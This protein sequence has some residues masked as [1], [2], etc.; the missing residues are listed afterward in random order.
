MNIRIQ[1]L[2]IALA[3]SAGIHQAAAQSTAFTYQGRLDHGS[4]VLFTADMTFTLFTTNT[5]GSPVGGPITN[6]Y[7]QA[8]SNGLFTTT[9]DFGSGIWTGT[10]PNWLEIGVRTNGIG[11][12]TILTPRQLITPTPQSIYALNAAIATSASNFSGSV[13]GDVSGPQGATEVLS[14]GGQ[15][16]ANIASG[17]IAANAATTANTPGTIVARD[18][19]GNFTASSVTLGGSLYLPFPAIIYSGSNT[20]MIEQGSVFI[21]AAD[22]PGGLGFA[23]HSAGTLAVGVHDVGV[24]DSA[25]SGGGPGFTSLDTGSY[26]TAIGEAAL[27]FNT[28]GSNNTAGGYAALRNNTS[29][30][31][32][33][34]DGY[35]ALYSNTTGSSNTANG[36]QA[37]Y[38]NTSGYA[39]TANGHQA[40]YSNTTGS[41][42]TA[43]GVSALLN[44]TS[45]HW[46]SAN[47]IETLF[48]NTSGY[49]NT[50]DGSL[51]LHQ[52][53]VGYYNTANGGAA[54]YSNTNGYYNS[55]NGAN[56]LWHNTSGYDNTANGMGALFFNTTGSDNTANGYLALDNNTTGSDNT[57]DGDQALLDTTGINNI[58]VGFGAGQN[59]TSG[60]DNIDIGNQGVAGE[61]DTI[62]IGTINNVATNGPANT[63]IAGIWDT[64]LITPVQTVVVDSSGHLGV[65]AGS[66][67]GSGVTSVT[68]N[69]HITAAPTTGAVVVGSDATPLDTF[70]TI[71]SRD[72]NGSFNANNIALGSAANCPGENGV[73]N[74]PATTATSGMITLGGCNDPFL[75]GYGSDNFFGGLNAGN[76]TLTGTWNVGVGSEALQ[77]VT[78]GYGNTASGFAALSV[79]TTGYGNT[80]SGSL[81]LYYN[82]TGNSNT[83][84]GFQALYV[85][86]SGF[87][88]TANGYQALFANTTGCQNTANGANALW[89]NTT[90]SNNTANGYLALDN[91]STGS[92]NTADGDQALL[93]TTG[94]NNIGVG[95]EAGQNLTTGNNNID[96]GNTGLASDNDTIRIGTVL[97]VSS[98]GPASTYIAGIY[99]SLVAGGTPVYAL[100]NGQLGTLTSSARYKQN[101]QS[102]ADASDV[103]L[104]LRP[105]T[106]QY[107]P[108]LDP[109]GIPQF[110][111]VAEEVDKIDPDLVVHDDRHGIYT[112]RY[113]AVNAMLLNEF[114]KQHQEIASLKEKAARV[115]SLESRLN[116]LQTLVKQLAGQK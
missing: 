71:V 75:H 67:S 47:G 111:L 115:D 31:D 55:A 96:I 1:H 14:V 78:T 11:A 100:A 110:G 59:L 85:N 73:L 79:N 29:G 9:I 103:L 101:I 84:N 26:N 68:G 82:A 46:N 81:A 5:D 21:G 24:G 64:T 34:A 72:I 113:E 38:S 60:N 49:H 3:L 112:V 10:T 87:S 89:N 58:G 32:N 102:M 95:F 28:T 20:M 108:G 37:L 48:N 25:L 12:F 40:L 4:N 53:T 90:G 45:G 33:K 54:L 7:V 56:A 23:G 116:E 104:S 35:E 70:G 50:A 88:D 74:L 13:S 93:N 98:N 16:A 17:V 106:Y 76:F 107:K 66:G 69:G 8:S 15:P 97:N 99:D 6:S 30:S 62:R 114:L 94:I 42:N 52:N 36:Y 80:A 41:S 105:V 39:N 77:N 2:L 57:A 61:S 109:K 18:S 44:N 51:S 19:S 27:Q 86:A 92:E 43:N 91:N 65:G 22:Y 63:Y 83:A